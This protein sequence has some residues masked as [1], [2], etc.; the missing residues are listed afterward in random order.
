MSVVFKPEVKWVPSYCYQC[1]AGGPDLLRVKVVDGVA[2]GLEGNLDFASV[3]PGGA[4]VCVKAY[5]LI[6]KHYN[7]NR[8]KAPLKRTN[9]KKGLDEDPGFVEITWDEAIELWAQKLLEVR[10]R[11]IVDENGYPRVAFAEGSD[12]VCPSYYG[13]LP[14]IFGGL[15]QA[16]GLPPGIW[17]PTEFTMAQGGGVKC[18]HTEHLLGEL[19]HKGFTCAQDTPLCDYI[20][21]IGRSDDTSFGVTGAKRQAEARARGWKRVQVEPHLSVTGATSDRW[22]PIR[23]ETDHAFLF[24]MIHVVLHEMNWAEVCDIHFLKTMTN[25]SYLVA[26][27]GYFLR[28]PVSEK[29]LVWDTVDRAAKPFDR[30]VK[31]PALEGEYEVAGI[32]L[33]PDSKRSRFDRVSVKPAFQ[34]LIEH[35]KTY[36]PEWA[37]EICDVPPQTIREL[38]HEFISHARVGATITVDGIEMPYRPVFIALGKTQNNGWGSMQCVWAA[39]VLQMLVGSLE[40]PGGHLGTRVL[41]SGPPRRTADGFLEYPFN[42]TDKENWRFPPGRRDGVPSLCPLTGPFLG[43]MHL[44]WKWTVDPPPHWPAPSVPDILITYKVNPVISQ[45]DTPTIVEV[46]RRIPF[47]V[48]F[49]Y[50]LDETAWFADLVLPEDG[51]LEALQVFPIGATT[52]MENFWEHVGLAIKQPAVPRANNTRNITDIATD[53][54]EKLGMLAAYNEALNHGAFLGFVLKDTPHELQPD[55]KYTAEEIYDRICKVATYNLSRGS[56]EFGLE[57]FKEKGAFFVPFPKVGPGISLGPIYMRP[58]YLYP[59]MRQSGIRFELPYQERLKRIGEE[60]QARISEAKIDW[61]QAQA[62]EY[63]AL[64]KWHSTSTII[65]DVIA[66][67]YGKNPNDYPF[68]LLATRSMQYAWGSNIAVPQMHEVAERVLGHTWVQMSTQ[69]G[70]LLGIKDGDEVWIESAYGKARG[71]VKLRE[72]IRADVVLT[73][74]MYGHVKTPF[75]K[76]LRLPNLN[77]IAPA[78]VELTDET[79]GSK[80]HVK[81]KVYK[82]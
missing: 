46:L 37:S 49:A 79:G 2:V 53:L 76:D 8:V 47:H 1:N 61:W 10:S 81:V 30:D 16:L 71:R 29:P 15:S 51:D 23:P 19:W 48:A 6:Q 55:K 13:T 77:Q 21:A 50:T 73:T 25:S 75:A 20:I 9:P 31:D 41:F 66:K 17:G 44:G 3:H 57:W 11:G 22:V 18:Y 38:T 26:P 14:V 69:A 80:D 32:T 5:G 40:V 36:T 68:W 82:P 65:D 7:P 12:G 64:P 42:P 78:L 45:F 72:G 62:H 24:A 60:L 39:H 54:A 43:P 70:R 67:R 58:W 63:Q 35:V 59:Y 4:K 27:D 56:E 34:L 52:F 33:G 28:D 74:Q